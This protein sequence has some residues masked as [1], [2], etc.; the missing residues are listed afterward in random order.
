MTVI[1][2][3]SV[4]DTDAAPLVISKP[5]TVIVPTAVVAIFTLPP[6]GIVADVAPVLVTPPDIEM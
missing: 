2:I 6:A 5:W 4:G 1:T 3:V